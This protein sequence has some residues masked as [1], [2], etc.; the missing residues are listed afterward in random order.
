MASSQAVSWE[1][2]QFSFPPPPVRASSIVDFGNEP[3]NLPAGLDS[4]SLNRDHGSDK[5]AVVFV[6]SKKLQ[7]LIDA[8]LAT[9]HALRQS[10]PR[11][12]LT[13]DLEEGRGITDPPASRRGS[14]A[15]GVGNRVYGTED[16]QTILDTPQAESFVLAEEGKR[17]IEA[18]CQGMFCHKAQVQGTD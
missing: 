14:S 6:S 15:G 12:S 8:L 16:L 1:L 7:S 4:T 2:A 9:T 13:D 18:F 11:T 10:L 3:T 5:D 17:E